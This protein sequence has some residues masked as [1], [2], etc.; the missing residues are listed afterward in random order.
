[1]NS[2]FHMNSGNSVVGNRGDG[3]M[4]RHVL[5]H[6]HGDWARAGARNNKAFELT[7]RLYL[8]TNLRCP[9][10]SLGAHCLRK[11]WV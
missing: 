8:I 9:F 7:Q 6:T 1:M 5:P 3:S 4:S 10:F 2:V 11:R